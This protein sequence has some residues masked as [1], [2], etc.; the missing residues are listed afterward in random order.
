MT[1]ETLRSRA[2][3]I[4]QLTDLLHEAGPRERDALAVVVGWVAEGIA[5]TGLD[6]SDPTL[7]TAMKLVKETQ[8][9]SLSFLQRKLGIG[10]NRAS[11][12][13]D[14]LEAGGIVGPIDDHGQRA[15]L[16]AR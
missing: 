13:V 3:L 7:A 5:Q 15:V 4:A 16:L 14:E 1:P 9:C 6:A 8:R 12:I 11:N 2:T 10:F